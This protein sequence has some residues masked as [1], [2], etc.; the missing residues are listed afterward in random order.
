[1]E[2]ESEDFC[3][4]CGEIL[5]TCDLCSKEKDK[6]FCSD[7]DEC[8]ECSVCLKI[9]CNDCWGLD[10]FDRRYVKSCACVCKTCSIDKEIIISNPVSNEELNLHNNQQIATEDEN[11]YLPS[12]ASTTF[13]IIEKQNTNDINLTHFCIGIGKEKH[14]E[15]EKK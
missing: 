3:K 1:M 8:D 2:D 14:S 13:H 9:I 6:L 4:N 15:F 7:C 5:W 10:L 11:L 12:P